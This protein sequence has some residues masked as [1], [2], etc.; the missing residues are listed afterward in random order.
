MERLVELEG[1]GHSLAQELEGHLRVQE[2]ELAQ[3][4]VVM[5]VMVLKPEDC[6][7]DAQQEVLPTLVA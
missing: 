5:V 7:P 4:L 6:Y 2:L 3:L 1:L